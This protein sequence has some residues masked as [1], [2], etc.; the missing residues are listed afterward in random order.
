MTKAQIQIVEAFPPNIEKIRHHFGD[1]PNNTV[2]T[3][4]TTIYNPGKGK[5]SEPLRIHELTHVAQQRDPY[6]WWDKYCTDVEFRLEQEV[7]AYS[8][9]F[10]CF[11]SMMKDR[12]KQVKYLHSIAQKLSGPLYGNIVTLSEAINKIKE[13]ADRGYSQRR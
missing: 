2:F 3:F 1:V 12:N 7:E 9:E 8:N 10:N 5:I 11:R 4:G 6:E 13:H